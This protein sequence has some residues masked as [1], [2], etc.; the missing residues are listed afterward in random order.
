MLNNR[1]ETTLASIFLLLT[2]LITIGATSILFVEGQVENANIHTAGDALW[3]V[4]VTISTVGYGDY[5]PVTTLGRIIA[6]GIIICGVGLFGMVAG[7]ISSVISDP[8]HEKAQ[9]EK[10]HRKEWREMLAN[11]QVLLARLERLEAKLDQQ[12]QTENKNQ[13]RQKSPTKQS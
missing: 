5:Y 10:E 2:V 11:Q 3:W 9:Q 8:Q 12:S 6:I 7:L 1:R 13:Q 4:F